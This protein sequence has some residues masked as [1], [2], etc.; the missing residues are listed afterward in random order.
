MERLHIQHIMHIHYDGTFRLH[1]HPSME[2][3]LLHPLVTRQLLKI[4]YQYHHYL[5]YKE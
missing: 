3:Q 1:K 4:I 2:R 5:R